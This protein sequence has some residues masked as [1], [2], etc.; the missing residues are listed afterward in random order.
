MS[1]EN[2]FVSIGDIC[3]LYYNTVL[4]QSQC[5]DYGYLNVCQKQK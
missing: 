5:G 3:W 2:K 4:G 1:I